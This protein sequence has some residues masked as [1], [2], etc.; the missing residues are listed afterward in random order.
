MPT[1][2]EIVEKKT[3]ATMTGLYKDYDRGYIGI[4]EQKMEATILVEPS[5]P[6]H[7]RY[8]PWYVM[9]PCWVSLLLGVGGWEQH[10][11]TPAIIAKHP[12]T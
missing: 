7:D 4:M 11:G 5:P 10:S 2:L 12:K 3:E 8:S 9:V 6:P 1:L